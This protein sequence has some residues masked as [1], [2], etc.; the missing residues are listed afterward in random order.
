MFLVLLALTAL[1]AVYAARGVVRALT[2]AARSRR[3]TR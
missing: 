1:S 2:D 3:R